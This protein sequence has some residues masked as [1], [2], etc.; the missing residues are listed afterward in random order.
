ML[1][2][3]IKI[4][5]FLHR[6]TENKVVAFLIIKDP[7]WTKISGFHLIDQLENIILNKKINPQL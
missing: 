1:K 7:L 2:N 4:S 3:S 5:N 6:D